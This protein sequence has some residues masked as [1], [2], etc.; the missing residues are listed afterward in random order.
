MARRPRR[1]HY[2]AFKAIAAVAAIKGEKTWIKLAQEF[3]IHPNRITFRH[4]WN[5][6]WLLASVPS[7]DFGFASF[8]VRSLPVPVEKERLRVVSF[9]PQSCIGDFIM[10]HGTHFLGLR[11]GGCKLRAEPF[12]RAVYGSLIA[13][14]SL[15]FRAP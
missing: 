7:Q 9:R 4:R 11:C 12:C 15:D 3:E 14:D 1:S 8:R 10:A 5:I 2:R 13:T 6:L